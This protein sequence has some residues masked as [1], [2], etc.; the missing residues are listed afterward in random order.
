MHKILALSALAC[1][2]VTTTATPILNVESS[3]DGSQ[4]HLRIDVA[5]TEPEWE[6][7]IYID[8]ARQRPLDN[9]YGLTFFSTNPAAVE[10]NMELILGFDGN[11]TV[12]DHVVTTTI[13]EGPDA[14]L[15]EG[16]S[17][18]FTVAEWRYVP[19]S[20][21][22]MPFAAAMVGMLAWRRRHLILTPP[23]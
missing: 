9:N 13:Q 11:F 16:P 14:L 10:F 20:M 2:C 5:G 12:G 1:A 6:T 23:R 22:S 3:Q 18:S 4:F 8:G 15:Y 19:D 17:G 7:L 21:G